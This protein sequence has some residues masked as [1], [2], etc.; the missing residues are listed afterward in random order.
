MNHLDA[1]ELLAI[2]DEEPARRIARIAAI[3]IMLGKAFENGAND[4]DES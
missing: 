4:N 1:T 2:T 3:L